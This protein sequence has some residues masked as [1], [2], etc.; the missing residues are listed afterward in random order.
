MTQRA[1]K[2]RRRSRGSAGKK[3]L[4]GFG[5]VLAI[6]VVG[7]ASVG[8]WVLNVWNSAP[9]IDTLKPIDQGETSSVYAADG[10]LLGY[11]EDDVI[12]EPVNLKEVPKMLRQATVAIEDQGFFEH[13]GVDYDAI[14][15]AAVENIEAGEIR[16]G[17]STITQQLV[18]NLYIANPDDTIERK[19]REAKLATELEEER[20]KGW[21]LKQY[22][23]TSPY[24]TNNGRTAI[25]VE[26][27][28]QVYFSKHVSDLNLWEAALLAGMP[29]APSQYNPLLSPG[30]AKARRNQVLRRMYDEGYITR[31]QKRSAVRRGFG[32]D[33]GYK[34]ETIRE[35]YFFTYVEQELIDRYGVNTVR[36]G[37]LEVHTTIQPGLQE[38]AEQAAVN[39]AAVLGGPS[40]ALA[41]VDPTNGHIV[42]MGSSASFES[43]QYNLAA[44]GHRQPG[45]AFK[46][47]VLTTALKQGIDPDST[48]YSGASPTTLYPYGEYGEPW[49]VQN[50]EGGSAG[51]MSLT[52][53]TTGSVNVVYAKLGIDV[54]PENTA[55]TAHDLGISS[56]LE[57]V[58]AEAIGGLGVGVS[59]LEM[60]NAYATFASGGI[61]HD[62]TAVAKV[63]FPNGDVDEPDT[64]GEQ[65][66]SDG[67][68]SEVTRILKT[69]LVSGTAAG[70]G[71]PGCP[72][73]GKTGTTDL[74][75]DAWFVGYT[76]TLS[77]A[78][79]VGY[80]GA[81]VPM[82]G[83]YGG[84][85]AAPAWNEF[86]TAATPTCDDFPE[87]TDIPE[88][89]SYESEYTSSPEPT[90][91][92]GSDYGAP[93]PTD[94]GTDTDTST[95]PD[96]TDEGAYN[97]EQLQAGANPAGD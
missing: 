10:S 83:A 2:S 78:V 64:E 47:F 9:S 94:T 25:G 66:I 35:P 44:Q 3:I 81:R 91:S 63:E 54:G 14:A 27:A 58:A 46:P 80:P 45:S 86:M 26:A 74:Q 8:A 85:Y 19:I 73:A 50:A 49:P 56:P 23:N 11:I 89:S 18:R 6:L 1:R 55:E 38:L 61:H 77:T 4:I 17:G 15:R 28:S 39:Q 24:G 20:T 7:V 52:S 82:P 95:E 62:P 16:Q 65:V 69:V 34:Y 79:W 22:L 30:A 84:T 42:A 5:V 87:P 31:D 21:I 70:L 51:T 93:A 76:T 41:S 68:A 71:V 43:S 96:T 37:G 48:Y 97:T 36:Q 59:P 67:I 57:G 13:D 72:S 29:Q 90:Y 32:L 12:R 75:A 92:Y 53:A 40:V 88:L 33:R 60:A